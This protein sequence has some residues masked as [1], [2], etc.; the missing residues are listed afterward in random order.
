MEEGRTRGQLACFPVALHPISSLKDP[1]DSG[2]VLT[3]PPN[4]A[5]RKLPQ[6][7]SADDVADPFRQ[8]SEHPGTAPLATYGLRASTRTSSRI[9]G[10]ALREFCGARSM[11]VPGRCL[12]LC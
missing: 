9:T 8:R 12:R 3:W 5:G 4:R 1:D 2:Q 7:I 6:P 10:F 11:R